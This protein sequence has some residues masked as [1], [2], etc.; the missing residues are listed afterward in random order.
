MRET[1]HALLRASDGFVP[2]HDR[3]ERLLQMAARRQR[4]RRIGSAL[5]AIAI[6]AATDL[7]LLRAFRPASLHPTRGGQV[8]VPGGS[9]V[10][11]GPPSHPL[12]QVPA[13]TPDAL[14]SWGAGGT[15]HPDATTRGTGPDGHIWTSSNRPAASGGAAHQISST[16]TNGSSSGVG[17]ST[18]PSSGANGS[19]GGSA[20]DGS[21]GSAGSSGGTPPPPPD[22]TPR[23]CPPTTGGASGASAPMGPAP[24]GGRV[25][26]PPDPAPPPPSNA[27]GRDGASSVGTRALSI[28]AA[29]VR[30][31]TA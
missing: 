21:S 1:H 16:G 20:G 26:E 11:I 7:G 8:V 5:L 24:V 31:P 30:R 17:G 28:A 22:P 19:G 10:P 4:N 6:F 29:P 2:A 9:G 3:W 12:R 13:G 23:P 15:T 25:C 18:S 14:G 27:P